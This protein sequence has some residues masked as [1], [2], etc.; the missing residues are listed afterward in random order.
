M[1]EIKFY[2]NADGDLCLTRTDGT[3]CVLATAKD[4]TRAFGLRTLAALT[5]DDMETLKNAH[6]KLLESPSAVL[7]L[8]KKNA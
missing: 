4:K 8:F 2:N 5:D 3:E 7:S 1:R 6:R